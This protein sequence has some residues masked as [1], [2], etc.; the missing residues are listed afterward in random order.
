MISITA[1]QQFCIRCLP[2]PPPIL[3]PRCDHPQHFGQPCAPTATLCARVSAPILRRLGA[4]SSPRSL[5]GVQS[6]VT[7]CIN[8]GERS[9][10]R[11]E[12]SPSFLGFLPSSCHHYSTTIYHCAAA[13]AMALTTQHTIISLIFKLRASSLILRLARHRGK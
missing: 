13:C 7:S 9:G 12:F 5:G 2:P 3:L 8:H 6:R 1:F 4:G 11:T 10:T